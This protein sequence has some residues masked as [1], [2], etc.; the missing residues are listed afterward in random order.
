[1]NNTSEMPLDSDIRGRFCVLKGDHRY[2]GQD[3][4]VMLPTTALFRTVCDYTGK[5]GCGYLRGLRTQILAV[6]DGVS[7]KQMTESVFGRFRPPQEQ[8]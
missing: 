8:P 7:E 4:T 1:L 2:V 6:S 3:R 5:V